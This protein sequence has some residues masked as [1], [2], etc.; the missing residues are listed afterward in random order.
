MLDPVN[1]ENPRLSQYKH[2]GPLGEQYKLY[3][4]YRGVLLIYNQHANPE[5]A[6]EAYVGRESL[7]ENL[8]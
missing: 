2:L 7:L 8:I 4:L 3:T 1:S 5:D 6:K